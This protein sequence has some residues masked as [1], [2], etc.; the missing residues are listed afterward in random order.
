MPVHT[1]TC[2]SPSNML[3]PPCSVVHPD[4]TLYLVHVPKG[5]AIS[6]LVQSW[7]GEAT[8]KH[9]H[10]Y[11]NHCRH[12]ISSLS[13]LF[14]S[15]QLWYACIFSKSQPV[16]PISDI[17]KHHAILVWYCKNMLYSEYK[18]SQCTNY[19]WWCQN[20]RNP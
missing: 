9:K 5:L 16:D 10:T 6:K 14:W 3:N 4:V 20:I 18:L 17:I 2:T 15:V 7:G 1:H 11:R 13:F 12:Y 8:K 19:Y